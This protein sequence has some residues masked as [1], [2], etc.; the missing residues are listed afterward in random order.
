MGNVPTQP[1]NGFKWAEPSLDGLNDINEKSFIGRV[2][3]VDIT[4]S[5]HLYSNHND[6]PF[7]SCN[8]VPPDSKKLMANS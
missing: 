5:Q 1:Y 4:Y 8:G 7:L 3:E 6:L 2:Y